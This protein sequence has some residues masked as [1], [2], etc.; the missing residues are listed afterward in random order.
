MPEDWRSKFANSLADIFL[1]PHLEPHRRDD[2][3][4]RNF[5]SRRRVKRWIV[6][7]HNIGIFLGVLSA[8]LIGVFGTNR[9]SELWETKGTTDRAVIDRVDDFRNSM[10]GVPGDI[11]QVNVN[12]E[13]VRVSV[14]D[15]S[16]KINQ[17]DAS[18]KDL[19]RKYTALD[20]AETNR[21][22]Q[23]LDG[24]GNLNTAIQTKLKRK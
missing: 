9:V 1:E 3:P 16:R 13:Q 12:L 22:E 8:L 20:E 14:D 7:A 18:L 15:L 19:A 24:I 17:L 6:M 4:D 11:R 5:S 10:L 21:N 23:L 2:P